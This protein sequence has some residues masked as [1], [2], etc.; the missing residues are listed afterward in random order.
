MVVSEPD[1]GTVQSFK[2]P[3]Q[4]QSIVLVAWVT[5]VYAVIASLYICWAKERLIEAN[6]TQLTQTAESAVRGAALAIESQLSALESSLELFAESNTDQLQ[7]FLHESNTRQSLYQAIA[8]RLRKEYPDMVSFALAE[9][10]G[11]PILEDFKGLIG[12]PCQSDLKAFAENPR[13]DFRRLHSNVFFHHFDVMANVEL[14]QKPRIFF[15][16]FKPN[17]IVQILAEHSSEAITLMLIDRDDDA[18][19]EMT[20]KG[21][22]NSYRRDWHLSDQENELIRANSF[23]PGTRWNLLA[24]AKPTHVELRQQVLHHQIEHLIFTMILG[25]AMLVTGSAFV[26][27][28]I[29]LHHIA[30]TESH[31]EM[32]TKAHHDALT[33]LPNRLLLRARMDMT[34]DRMRREKKMAAVIFLDLDHFKLINDTLG[35]SIGDQVLLQAAERLNQLRRVDTVARLSGDEFVIVLSDVHSKADVDVVAFELLNKIRNI[36]ET[37]KLNIQLSASIGIALYPTDG[38]DVDTLLKHADQAMYSVKSAGRD[39]YRFYVERG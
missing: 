3:G 2:K 36:S 32:E 33:G 29:R 18:L 24:L 22:R 17:L 31:A 20:E 21:A 25:G 19:I 1:S 7:T 10:D 37:L 11:K 13:S 23:I 4:R 14:D 30:I 38:E 27:Y 34:L 5:L 15:A 28:R 35:H 16:N 12:Q 39:G 8:G 6:Q 26:C 9:P